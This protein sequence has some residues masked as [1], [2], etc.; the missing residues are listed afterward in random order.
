MH[1]QQ[2]TKSPLIFA[3]CARQQRQ[4]QDQHQDRNTNPQDQDQDIP[5]VSQTVLRQHTV[6]R[7]NIAASYSRENNLSREYCED[8]GHHASS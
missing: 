8:T 5:N 1:L 2:V 7:L 4:E 3:R 6:S